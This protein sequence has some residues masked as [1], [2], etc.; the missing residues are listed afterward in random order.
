MPC[1][2]T[3]SVLYTVE[4][5]ISSLRHLPA[6]SNANYLP[7]GHLFTFWS[8]SPYRRFSQQIRLV[9]GKTDG[10]AEARSLCAA[11][12]DE[13]HALLADDAAFRAEYMRLWEGQR[14]HP[15]SPFSVCVGTAES[16][17]GEPQ[18]AMRGRVKW[19]RLCPAELRS[20][21]HISW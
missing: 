18:I 2:R 15:I 21:Q 8:A 5:C 17:H 10:L 16:E 3:L 14:K 6:A 20:Q 13:A 4:E 1:L 12:M 9:L 19:C 11:Q 7:G